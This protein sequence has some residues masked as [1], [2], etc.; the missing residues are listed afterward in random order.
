MNHVFS[1]PRAYPGQQPQEHPILESGT[2]C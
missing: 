1:G 2:S